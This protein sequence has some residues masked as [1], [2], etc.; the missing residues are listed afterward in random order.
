MNK[1][2]LDIE[3]IPAEEEKHKLLKE[4]YD[5]DLDR[6]KKLSEWEDY[7]AE[8][9]FDG[10]FGRI[11]CISY[12]INDNNPVSLSGDETEILKKF[13]EIAR[14]A[15]LFIGFNLLNFDLKFIYQRSM[16][17][18][19]RPSID[20]NFARYKNFPIFDVMQEWNKWDMRSSISL[21]KLAKALNIPS[22]KDGEIEGK[23]VGQAYKE[24]RIKKICEY[25]QRDVE[26]TRTI[27][28]K[29]TFS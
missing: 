25:C 8:T 23:D 28:K 1:L 14:E 12:A 6:G 13:W 9:N 26:A 10:A 17:H 22:P 15:D 7:L 11:C 2:F 21:H 29:L 18:G 19:I 4:I 27:Y 16:I 24:G 5:R 3:T 20:L